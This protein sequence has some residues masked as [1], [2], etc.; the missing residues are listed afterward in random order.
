ML[1]ASQK[2]SLA[3]KAALHALSLSFVRLYKRRLH[4]RL[5]RKKRLR[6]R[7]VSAT[8]LAKRPYRAFNYY[9]SSWFKL[10][11]NPATRDPTTIQ[12]KMFRKR[13]RVPFFLFLELLV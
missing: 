1:I 4:A 10:I 12:G 2:R 6:P 13:F 7:H 5:E 11:S 9:D 3:Y 8:N